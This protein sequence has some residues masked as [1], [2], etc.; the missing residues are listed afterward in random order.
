M[1]VTP[2]PAGPPGA[3]SVEQGL[4]DLR[5]GRESEAALL[6]QI[7]APR[8]RALGIEIPAQ[9]VDRGESAEHRLHTLL[10]SHPGGGRRSSVWRYR[11]RA[12]G[13][14]RDVL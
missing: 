5:A 14:V 3:D 10:S 6:V 9:T 1:R 11:D 2:L 8:L 12:S 13:A 7:A 4:S